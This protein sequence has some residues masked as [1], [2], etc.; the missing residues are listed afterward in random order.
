ML[1]HIVN[2]VQGSLN[3]NVFELCEEEISVVKDAR[4]SSDPSQVVYGLDAGIAGCIDSPVGLVFVEL[5]FVNCIMH[6]IEYQVLEIGSLSRDFCFG[7]NLMIK[8]SFV[9]G[10]YKLN[11]DSQ[12]KND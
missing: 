1:S 4:A 2:E 6:F 7:R 3:H 8:R 5:I 10:T 9:F 12:R 11:K